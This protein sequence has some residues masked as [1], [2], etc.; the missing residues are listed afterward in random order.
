MNG[1]AWWHGDLVTAQN[2]WVYKINSERELEPVF[3]VDGLIKEIKTLANGEIVVLS[4]EGAL[5]ISENSKGKEIAHS[6]SEFHILDEDRIMFMTKENQVNVYYQAKQIY[7]R[8]EL[9]RVVDIKEVAGAG[10]N[11]I[12]VAYPEGIY[13]LGLINPN[14]IMEKPSLYFEMMIEDKIDKLIFNEVKEII[15]YLNNKGELRE[16]DF[17]HEKI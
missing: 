6:V 15:Y 9:P 5:V 10:E 13:L 7:Q 2:N 8:F 17:L 12:I 14:V 3:N 11:H 16:V 4:R 1:I